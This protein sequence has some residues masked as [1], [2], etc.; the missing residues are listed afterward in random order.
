VEKI[1][2]CNAETCDGKHVGLA[3]AVSNIGLCIKCN[4]NSLVKL[5]RVLFAHL[6]DPFQNKSFAAIQRQQELPPRFHQLLSLLFPVREKKN[7]SGD[8][9][10]KKKKLTKAF[11]KICQKCYR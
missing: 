5:S 7:V 1:A 8:R 6:H 10:K 9:K 11:P 4:H 3:V 2:N